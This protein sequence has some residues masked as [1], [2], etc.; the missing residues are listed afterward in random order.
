MRFTDHQVAHL[1][2]L[3]TVT[4]VIGVE[5]GSGGDDHGAQLERSQHGFPQRDIVAEHQQHAFAPAHTQGAQVVGHLV[6]ARRELLEAV[7]LLAAVLFDDPQRIRRVAFCHRI[8][9]VQGPV[10]RVQVWPTEVA[11]GGGVVGTVSEQKSRAARKGWVMVG[12]LDY[13]CRDMAVMLRPL[14]ST[15]RLNRV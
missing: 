4:Q 15:G 5:Q 14:G 10:E 7:A 12:V 1:A 11:H 8:E 2:A 13:C 6:G 9:V 3:D